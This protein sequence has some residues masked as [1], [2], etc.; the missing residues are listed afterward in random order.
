M[1][2]IAVNGFFQSILRK[3]PEKIL[4]CRTPDDMEDA[5]ASGKCAAICL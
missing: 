4:Q 3:Y 2:A 5:F 1:D